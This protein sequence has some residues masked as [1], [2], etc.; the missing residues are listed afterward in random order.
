MSLFCFL[1]GITNGAP[2]MYKRGLALALMTWTDFHSALPAACFVEEVNE[3]G[4]SRLA[5]AFNRPMTRGHLER[6]RHTYVALGPSGQRRV[7]LPAGGFPADFLYMV[8]VRL[9]ELVETCRRGK[10]L[11]LEVTGRTGFSTPRSEWR[12]G[13]A[14]RVPALFEVL[15]RDWLRWTLL[16]A[17]QAVS[18][19]GSATERR[20]DRWSEVLSGLGKLPQADADDT[21]H[22]RARVRAALTGVAYLQKRKKPS[23]KPHAE[24]ASSAAVL[25]QPTPPCDALTHPAASSSNRARAKRQ[26]D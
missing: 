15:P 21:M 2:S 20:R 13:E 4:L 11:V 8:E 18:Q 10:V 12:R 17:L 5:R 22:A 26:R 9:E 7:H 14:I 3:A 16:D 1:E 24:A 19:G 23:T 25:R 6:L